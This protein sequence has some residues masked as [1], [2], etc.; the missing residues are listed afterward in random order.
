MRETK[1][2]LHLFKRVIQAE[3]LNYFETMISAW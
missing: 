3:K 2:E 1:V